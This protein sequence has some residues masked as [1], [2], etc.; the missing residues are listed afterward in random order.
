MIAACMFVASCGYEVIDV[1][2]ENVVPPV[3][4][5]H[6]HLTIG[7]LAEDPLGIY[8]DEYEKDEHE[9]DECEYEEIIECEP[10]ELDE[11]C[12]YEYYEYPAPPKLMIALTFDDGPSRY[13]N[14]I[15]DILEQY[16]ARATFCVLGM[17]VANWADT[18]QRAVELNNEI[19][20]HS[21]NHAN[22]SLHNEDF[23]RRQIVDTSAAI[24][25][26]TG[27]P[28]PPIFRAPYGIVNARVQRVAQ[29]LGYSTLNWTVDPEDWRN[30]DANIIYQ[31]I[32][33]RAI[34]GSIILLH[35]IRPTTVEAMTLVVPSLIER[36]FELV[37]A[38][39]LIEYVYGEM[40]PGM[41]Y[42]GLRSGGRPRER[43]EFVEERYN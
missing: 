22:L 38:S 6:A 4:V 21:W 8:E 33:A 39:E 36:G 41:G 17:N 9:E 11:Y 25:A 35:D 43:E 24:E 15:L 31:H 2:A 3:D 10:Y 19:I 34:D 32:M 13:T 18:I 5:L 1:G 42:S 30:R 28:P 7:V 16:G 37:T 40:V 20:G 29:E 27:T 26:V 12:A 14:C 23:I